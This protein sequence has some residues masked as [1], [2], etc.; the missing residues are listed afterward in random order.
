MSQTPELLHP[1]PR[2][3]AT[4]RPGP[5]EGCA[6]AVP[7]WNLRKRLPP[8]PLAERFTAVNSAD[9]T[10]ALLYRIG[11]GNNPAPTRERALRYLTSCRHPHLQRIERITSDAEGSTWI[12]AEYPGSHSGL[13]TLAELL[14][15]KPT[16][17]LS[18]REVWHTT[19]HLLAALDELHQQSIAHGTIRAD[20]ILVDPRGRVLIELP[21]ANN[22]LHP[23]SL[24]LDHTI[25]E[26]LRSVARL[27]YELLTG[28]P[29][30][31]ERLPVKKAIGFRGRRWDRWIGLA[32]EPAGGFATAREAIARLG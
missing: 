7:G 25:R 26:D 20:D 23:T 8:H 3:A 17:T 6:N 14:S 15:H 5:P 24:P 12:I 10:P 18:E 4:Q 22:A 32:L 11:P 1:T 27:V 31:D 2:T 30:N 16:G 19:S 29:C 9:N 28:I 13:L 21:G